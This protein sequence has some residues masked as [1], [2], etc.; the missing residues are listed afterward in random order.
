MRVRAAANPSP[1]P[2]V[3][4]SGVPC[5]RGGILAKGA[6]SVGRRAVL[7]MRVRKEARRQG[8]G[9]GGRDGG[10]QRAGR[11]EAGAYLSP[12]SIRLS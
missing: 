2:A 11:R 6:C 12:K 3:R 10:G 1:N 7:P 9:E 8:A 5:R 4:A